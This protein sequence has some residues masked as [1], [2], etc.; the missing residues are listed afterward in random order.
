M[1]IFHEATE[2]DFKYTDYVLLADALLDISLKEADIHNRQDI[3]DLIRVKNFDTRPET[4]KESLDIACKSIHGEYLVPRS[5]ASLKRMKTFKIKELNVGFALAPMKGASGFCEIVALHNASKY[6]RLGMHLLLAA[7]DLGGK[8]LECFG[9]VL[10]GKLYMAYG[11]EVYKTL[12]NIKMRNGK[13]ENLY[14]MKLKWASN[15]KNI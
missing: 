3:I 11:F 7:E 12:D 4:F 5:L 8:Y 15:P 10:S 1:I 6:A 2:L 9:D 13:I 14:F